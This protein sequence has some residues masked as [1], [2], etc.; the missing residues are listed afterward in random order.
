M[1]AVGIIGSPRSTGNTARVVEEVLR[2]VAAAG[3]AAEKILLSSRRIAP[4]RGCFTCETTGACAIADDTR[5]VLDQVQQADLLVIGTPVYFGH[6]SGQLKI[7]VD[8]CRCLLSFREALPGLS[9]RFD[10]ALQ[11]ARRRRGAGPSPVTRLRRGKLAVIVLSYYQQG[12]E[13][14][15][16]VS[17]WLTGFLD[18]LGVRTETAIHVD[19]V[20]G[21]EDLVSRPQLLQAAYSLGLALARRSAS[22]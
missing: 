14:F 10:T 5:A 4:C 18:T 7:F 8:R 15:R 19:G 6:V 22:S 20:L 3:G 11:A 21:E 1:K 13:R 12:P 17:E 9:G 2:G 16:H